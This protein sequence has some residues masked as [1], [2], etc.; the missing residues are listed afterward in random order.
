MAKIEP[1][2]I[3]EALY[4]SYA[5]LGMA[6]KAVN[7]QVDKYKQLHFIIRS[8]LYHGLMN[9]NMNVRSLFHDEKSKLHADKCC[10]YCGSIEK[11]SI[12][13]IIP[14]KKGGNDNGE[15]LVLACRKC[16]CSKNDTDLLTWYQK[17]NELPPLKILRNYLKIVIQYCKE[18]D[19]MS[20][21]LDTSCELNLPFAIEHIPFNY[22][23]PNQLFKR[24]S[25]SEKIN[26]T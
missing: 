4:W 5:N 3:G 14:Q 25:I 1:K 17:R 9:G 22:P 2:T 16:N 6:H 15:N 19:L 26:P 10:V 13:H 20:R 18:N 7:D 24:H 11:L 8:K 12:D 23:T 21:E